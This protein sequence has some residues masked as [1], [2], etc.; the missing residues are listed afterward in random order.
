MKMKVT[1]KHLLAA[2]EIYTATFCAGLTAMAETA[3]PPDTSDKIF[4]I[5]EKLTEAAAEG[6]DNAID[7]ACLTIADGNREI[8][9]R[10]SVFAKTENPYREARD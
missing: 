5:A 2:E 9:Q 3:P 6:W 1:H 7:S 10:Y 8:A 4:A